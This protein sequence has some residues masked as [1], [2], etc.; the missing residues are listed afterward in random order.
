MRPNG[1]LVMGVAGSGKTAFGKM[2][3]ERLSWDFFDADDYHPSENIA[4]M[5][6]GIPLN[7]SDRIPWLDT[8]AKL[9]GT[10]LTAGHHPVL[11]CSALKEVYRMQLLDG[12][13]RIAIIYLKGSY[14]LIWSRLS[15]RQG[16]YMKPDM[17]RSQFETLEEP[18]NALVLDISMTLDEMVEMVMEKWFGVANG[19]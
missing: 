16:H 6:A 17:L 2:L 11:A 14:E 3:A 19:S 7:D 10:T 12:Q 1:F 8:L 15:A 9:L 5:A 4:K 13:S 18:K